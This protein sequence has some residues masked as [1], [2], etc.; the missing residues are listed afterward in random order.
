MKFHNA[1]C[2]LCGQKSCEYHPDHD[3]YLE[4]ETRFFGVDTEST[5]ASPPS[6]EMPPMNQAFIV[7]MDEDDWWEADDDFWDA[8]AKDAESDD[9]V[10]D[11]ILDALT[12]SRDRL[13]LENMRL[14]K[15]IDKVNRETGSLAMATVEVLNRYVS[16]DEAV[17][18]AFEIA[19]R[20]KEIVKEVA[21][22]GS[23]AA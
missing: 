2:V 15:E 4:A 11:D 1:E 3:L 10:K 18:L 21:D 5:Q 14:R 20:A 22:A 17:T 16:F 19:N 6:P 12:K 8:K 7:T 9:F 23:E 13:K